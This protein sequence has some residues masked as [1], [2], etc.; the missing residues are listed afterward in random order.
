MSYKPKPARRVYLTKPNGKKRPIGIAGFRDKLVQTVV[1]LLLG[2]HLRTNL[3][4]QLTWFPTGTQL[5]YGAAAGQRPCGYSLVD[6]GRHKEFLRHLQQDVL[7]QI[8]NKRITD[9][10]F[11]HL[12]SQLMRAGYMENWQFHQTYSGVPQG[13]CLSPVLS[14]IYLNELD[15]AM[16]VKAQ[17]VQPW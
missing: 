8:L 9:Q 7:L 16:L 2:G 13:S 11:L 1:K 10:R 15:Q 17:G 6:R 3:C 14:N 4:R 5:P 12:I